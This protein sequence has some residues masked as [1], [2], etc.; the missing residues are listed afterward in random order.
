MA[1]LVESFIILTAIYSNILHVNIPDGVENM[2]ICYSD[3][4]SRHNFT[5]MEKSTVNDGKL[6]VFKSEIPDVATAYKLKIIFRNRS[7]GDTGWLSIQATCSKDDF[8]QEIKN[9]FALVCFSATSLVVL[10]LKIAVKNVRRK[11]K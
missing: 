1:L 7:E 5:I 8:K 10:L 6:H 3:C 2:A 9:I 4:T 11:L